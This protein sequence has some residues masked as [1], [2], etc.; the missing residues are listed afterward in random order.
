MIYAV[1]D[2]P[3]DFI[4][5]FTSQL[6]LQYTQSDNGDDMREIFKGIIMQCLMLHNEGSESS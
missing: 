5:F 1:E 2:F 3:G 6:F 4:D